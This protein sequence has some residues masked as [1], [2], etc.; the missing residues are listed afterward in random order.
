MKTLILI[1]AILPTLATSA[2]STW[3][4]MSSRQK[5]ATTGAAVVRCPSCR[6]VAAPLTSHAAPRLASPDEV[7][8][9]AMTKAPTMA[10]TTGAGS[11]A[12]GGGRLRLYPQFLF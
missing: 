1:P 7:T 5:S 12:P 3:D 9:V 10:D 2:C 6:V 11:R 4:G 8:P